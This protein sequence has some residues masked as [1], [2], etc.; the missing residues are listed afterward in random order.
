MSRREGGI[1]QRGLN[2]W[3]LKFDVATADGKRKTIR[4]TVHAPN[5]AAAQKL[6]TARLADRDNGSR[7]E[8]N[9]TTV[10]EAVETS[11]AA[12]NYVAK[13]AARAREI[14]TLHIVPA[15][16]H[17]R[18]QDLK[19]SEIA[20]WQLTLQNKRHRGRPLSGATLVQISKIL[21]QALKRAT[22]LGLLTRNPALGV[23]LPKGERKI[24]TVLS[25]AQ[26]AELVDGLAADPWPTM[27]R[28]A[29]LAN[30][31]GY[32]GARLAEILAMQRGDLDLVNGRWRLQ[33]SFEE[34][35]GAIVARPCKTRSSRRTIHLGPAM[36]AFLTRHLAVQA[37]RRLAQGHRVGPDDV[38]F[39][40]GTGRP[41]RP[42]R[43]SADWGKAV[44]RLKFTPRINFHA[45]RH[46]Y[47]SFAIAAGHSVLELS[48]DLGHSNVVITLSLY[49]HLMPNAGSSAAAVEALLAAGRSPA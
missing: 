7:V 37:E 22:T 28:L 10:A 14:A 47:A 41:I 18:L 45:L 23:P 48:R 39:D 11:I 31:A 26:F 4:E 46:F 36:V 21:R 43:I 2:S 32:T 13:F 6:L 44:K 3:Q 33:R 42:N 38:V 49:A 40:D 25:A 17:H 24:M 8:P 15:L 19:P 35:A 27:A 5:R 34:V 1:T 16:G 20:D 12:A 29:P 9:N 30:C